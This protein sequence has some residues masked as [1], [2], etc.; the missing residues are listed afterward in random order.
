[1][2]DRTII[3]TIIMDDEGEFIEFS[4]HSTPL[5]S[6]GFSYSGKTFEKVEDKYIFK[7]DNH[8]IFEPFS[9]YI[10]IDNYQGMYGISIMENSSYF[11]C[12]I[13]PD[14]VNKFKTSIDTLL[15]KLNIAVAPH[16]GVLIEGDDIT[17]NDRNSISL[18]DFEDGEECVLIRHPNGNFTANG[19]RC[20]VYHVDSLQGWF[21]A[22]NRSE[23]LTRVPITQAMLQ[24]FNYAKPAASAPAARKSRKVRKTR[25]SRK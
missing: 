7:Y 25:R 2:A 22:G 15:A 18:N 1:M 20:F 19:E 23:P 8:S 12:A 17:I 14:A 10:E 13:T 11:N 3:D 4:H 5:F 6:F 24:R 21:D 16:I 9:N